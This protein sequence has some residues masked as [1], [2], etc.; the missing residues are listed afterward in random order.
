MVLSQPL[1][2]SL[3]ISATMPEQGLQVLPSGAREITTVGSFSMVVVYRQGIAM[4]RMFPL[5]LSGGG[6]RLFSM[7]GSIFDP[8]GGVLDLQ[9]NPAGPTCLRVFGFPRSTVDLHFVGVLCLPFS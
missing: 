5:P 8:I 2:S 6:S 3:A 4:G 7:F 1:H 9:P